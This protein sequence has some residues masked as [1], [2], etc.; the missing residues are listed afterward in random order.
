[1]KLRALVT[2]LLLAG[3]ASAS[4]KP[5]EWTAADVKDAPRPGREHGRLDAIDPGDSVARKVGRVVLFP[6]RIPVEVVMFPVRFGLLFQSKRRAGET[7]EEPDADAPRTL[8]LQPRFVWQ[9]GFYPHVG[10]RAA[11]ANL[12]DHDESAGLRIGYGGHAGAVIGADAETGGRFGP[13]G[14]GFDARYE[15][16]DD[17]RF[18]GFGNDADIASRYELRV[19]RAGGWVRFRPA[20]GFSATL[21]GDA[22]SKRYQ[23][24][25]DPYG[26]DVSLEQAFDPVEV[27]GFVEGADFVRGELELAYD[28]RRPGNEYEP[29][30]VRTKG[31]LVSAYAAHYTVDG[32]SDF[33]R[34]GFDLQQLIRIT[35]GP[36]AIELRLIGE[37]M[38]GD[39][40]QTPFTEV[41]VL[42][43][44]VMHSLQVDRY[45][46]RVAIAG[47]AG[48]LWALN[49]TTAA[50]LFAEAGRVAPSVSD[51]D[52]GDLRVGGGLALEAYTAEGRMVV[53]E[54]AGSADG[55]LFS[56]GINPA[57]D[58]RTRA[59]D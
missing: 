11:L 30:A 21:R 36:R 57:T 18:F 14:L 27:P 46:D 54:V 43:N 17:E 10:V 48:Y 32:G 37:G 51:L 9:S 22:I 35:T 52:L 47:R 56:L 28:T 16:R 20:G 41:P 45:R 40:D 26:D 7:A 38:T 12:G 59:R 39:L 1:M 31:S 24:S 49:S 13:I 2:A 34:V 50:L 42:G 58:G 5:P 15:S 33:V 55:V 4:A 8:Q 6:L 23:P 25:D 3:G 53:A 44:D 19:R 29:P